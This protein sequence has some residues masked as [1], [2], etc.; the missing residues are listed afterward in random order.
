MKLCQSWNDVCLK[1]FVE[2]SKLDASDEIEYQIAVIAILSNRS[3]KEIEDL[4]IPVLKELVAKTAFVTT[5]PHANPLP[6]H[7]KVNGVKYEVQYNVSDLTGGKYIDLKTFTKSQQNI[8]ENLHNILSV[9]VLPMEKKWGRWKLK[10]YDAL[11]Q[12]AIADDILNH[13]SVGVAYPIAV[14]FCKLY[15]NLILGTQEFMLEK[16]ENQTAQLMKSLKRKEKFRTM[17]IG[18]GS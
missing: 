10:K 12:A 1:Q 17:S 8:L 14:F 9:F 15:E 7:M 3:K 2:L 5:L 4:P 18:V 13:F 6:V 11:N 16:A